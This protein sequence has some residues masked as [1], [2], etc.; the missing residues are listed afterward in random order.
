M[1]VNWYVHSMAA[2]YYITAL[3]LYLSIL[4][5]ANNNKTIWASGRTQVQHNRVAFLID[6]K[7]N[8][9]I[10]TVLDFKLIKFSIT[11]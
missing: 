3:F 9:H 8:D 1:H 6:F 7:E 11:N 10:D 2:I 4:N 5:M